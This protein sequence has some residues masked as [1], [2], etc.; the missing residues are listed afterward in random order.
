MAGG[1]VWCG[2]L[3]VS[4]SCRLGVVVVVVARQSD[5]KVSERVRFVERLIGGRDKYIHYMLM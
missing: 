1:S 5:G 2:V 4:V 3:L